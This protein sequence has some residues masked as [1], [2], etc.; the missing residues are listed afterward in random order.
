MKDARGLRRGFSPHLHRPRLRSLCS[1][2]NSPGG[3][4]VA[5]VGALREG[6]FCEKAV[7]KPRLL[8]AQKARRK[9]SR[10]VVTRRDL[11]RERNINVRISIKYAEK[12]V[13]GRQ[14][15]NARTL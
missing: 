9:R 3:Q 1:S 6:R 12:K 11:F 5:I 4:L 2:H 15:D 7:I 14:R 10:E 13:V 8:V